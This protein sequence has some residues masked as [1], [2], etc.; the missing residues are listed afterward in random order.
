M[1][2]QRRILLVDDDDSVREV[3]RACLEIVGGYHVVSASSGQECL[4]LSLT[5]RPDAILLD[6]MMPGLDG[7]S[8]FV[9]LQEQEETRNLP[10]V[11]LT[12]KTQ[13]ADLRRFAEL[14]V[15]GVI[16]KPFEPM[17]LSD[18]VAELFGWTR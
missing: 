12:A 4:E 1:P 7:P 15:A 3:T 10:V 2:S 18:Q 8:T 17:K 9:R 11:L 13:E 16:R 14:G 6:V 5:S